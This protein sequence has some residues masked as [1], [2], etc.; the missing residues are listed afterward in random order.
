MTH[1]AADEVADSSLLLQHNRKSREE[2]FHGSSG[3][4]EGFSQGITS[5][6]MPLDMAPPPSSSSVSAKKR[7]ARSVENLKENEDDLGAFDLF[8]AASDGEIN[9]SSSPSP[10]QK[11]EN[12]FQIKQNTQQQPPSSQPHEEPKQL[13]PPPV[14]NGI[15]SENSSRGKTSITMMHCDYHSIYPEEKSANS[16]QSIESSNPQSSVNNMSN[17]RVTSITM[18]H[19]NYH[20]IY[21]EEG[22]TGQSPLTGMPDSSPTRGRSVSSTTVPA[23]SCSYDRDND[24]QLSPRRRSDTTG[25]TPYDLQLKRNRDDL[26]DTSPRRHSATASDRGYYRNKSNSSVGSAASGT[27]SSS[28]TGSKVVAGRPRKSSDATNLLFSATLGFSNLLKAGSRDRLQQH[29]SENVAEM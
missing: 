23:A 2:N 15:R 13:P 18:M 7:Q 1:T 25:G 24:Q 16:V 14:S 6:T 22:T 5:A 27:L 3:Y 19:C 8:R 26:S 11:E 29:N 28:P 9:Q 21:P 12:Y 20:S 10:Y 17:K 4:P